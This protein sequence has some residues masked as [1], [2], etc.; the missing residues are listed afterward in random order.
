MP[1]L[2]DTDITKWSADY[3]TLGSGSANTPRT[4]VD[5]QGLVAEQ[6]QNVKSVVRAE[7]ESKQWERWNLTATWLNNPTAKTARY[8][9]PGN[10]LTSASPPGPVELNR[11]VLVVTGGVTKVGYV[12]A[13]G[14]TSPTVFR[15]A[16]T[17]T[18]PAASPSEMMFGALTLSGGGRHIYQTGTTSIA[19]PALS[20]TVT[21]ASEECDANYSVFM[22]IAGLTGGPWTTKMLQTVIAFASRTTTGFTF[23]IREF[24]ILG[25]AIDFYWW[26]VR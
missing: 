17:T 7:S 20:A 24:M 1:T 26:I 8:S 15:V 18:A 22:E 4:F 6:V 10:V 5:M 16:F 3:P 25:E 21:F 2:T 13:L 19:Y 11:M 12:T 9:I 14:T 23:S